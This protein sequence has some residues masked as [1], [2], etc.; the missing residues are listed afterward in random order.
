MKMYGG[1]GCIVPRFLDLGG[2]KY[3]ID[4]DNSSKLYS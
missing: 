2:R 4:I 1:S 3:I